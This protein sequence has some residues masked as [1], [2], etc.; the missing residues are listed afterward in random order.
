MKD[1]HR[2]KAN[3]QEVIT[4][5]ERGWEGL[6]PPPVFTTGQPRPTGVD[7][8]DPATTPVA[9]SFRLPDGDLEPQS[10]Q[11]PPPEPA[12]VPD[13]Y[14]LPA[15]ESPTVPVT[16]SPSISVSALSDFTTADVS[17]DESPVYPATA[18]TSDEELLTDPT[19][20]VPHETFYIEDG[21]VEVLCGNKLFRVHTTV[22]S[23]HSPTLR[24]M[25]AP[26]N[27]VATESPN[28]CPRILSSDTAKDFATLLK[29]IYFPGSVTL[30]T[31]R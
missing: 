11:T 7:Q 27:L 2:A 1:G 18:D 8:K 20:V 4:L 26:T 3:L 15:S 9:T 22:L 31:C 12:T 14:T 21:N 13:T 30:P 6:P 24:R 16:Q 19:A 17:N 28:G 5:R 23:F 29:M 25:F 10:P